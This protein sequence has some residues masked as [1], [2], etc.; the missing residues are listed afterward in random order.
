LLGAAL[1]AYLLHRRAR[2]RAYRPA[3]TAPDVRGV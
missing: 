1:F 2:L 3:K